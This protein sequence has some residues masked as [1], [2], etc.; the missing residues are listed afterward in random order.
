M[1]SK[2]RRHKLSRQTILALKDDYRA[3]ADL[4]IMTRRSLKSE[5]EKLRFEMSVV[6]TS[7]ISHH[8]NRLNDDEFA[9][10]QLLDTNSKLI[11]KSFLQAKRGRPNLAKMELKFSSK[12]HGFSLSAL[13][14]QVKNFSP[15]LIL[16][17]SSESDITFGSFLSCPLICDTND[18]D[19]KDDNS[20]IGMKLNCDTV[21][22][23]Y[24]S[25]IFK[26][27]NHKS[28]CYCAADHTA[29]RTLKDTPSNTMYD[30]INAIQRK[31]LTSENM[32]ERSFQNPFI[33]TP[34]NSLLSTFIDSSDEHNAKRS[35]RGLIPFIDGSDGD[36]NNLWDRCLDV[37]SQYHGNDDEDPKDN[38]DDVKTSI[39][40]NL[41][42]KRNYV[43][44]APDCISI[45]F[46]GGEV[47]NRSASSGAISK[48]R[49]RK[50]K[51]LPCAI[52]LQSD[53]RW[54]YCDA[55]DTFGN[56][57][58]LCS[59]GNPKINNGMFAIG[60]IE[61]Y[62]GV[63][64]AESY[65][66]AA[67]TELDMINQHLD[68]ENELK[69][70][71]LYNNKEGMKGKNRLVA[72]DKNLTNNGLQKSQ[73][74]ENET[75]TGRETLNEESFKEQEK[76]LL[77]EYKKV[78]KFIMKIEKK[79]ERVATVVHNIKAAHEILLS[80]NEKFSAG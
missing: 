64:A 57:T 47:D 6:A 34:D 52:R 75:F 37:P 30:L 39:E 68:N 44:C 23:D 46:C 32:N 74:N 18:T 58:A 33:L 66:R 21:R 54:V 17:K 26:L 72:K 7:V 36:E 14:D 73:S 29:Y 27:D 19:G 41:T 65:V 12:Q 4:N 25:C 62:C 38:N 63:T 67:D 79:R 61:V 1:L 40:T 35:F 48:R 43:I 8:H 42:S 5:N 55:S 15:C 3:K 10:S 22:G 80:K 13:Y 2:L 60:S 51:D 56:N 71:D 9:S 50:I 69:S 77:R 78:K 24:R 70:T 59:D 45:G 49:P 76:L 28:L 11:L 20:D 53:L 31:K 16:M